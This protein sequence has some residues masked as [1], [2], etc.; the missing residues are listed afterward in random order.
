MSLG[1]KLTAVATCV[2]WGSLRTA[3]QATLRA[4]ARQ[5]V[6][7]CEKTNI[8]DIYDNKE[9]LRNPDLTPL[10]NILLP[11]VSYDPRLHRFSWAEA[12]SDFGLELLQLAQSRH[13]LTVEWAQTGE[14]L[15]QSLVLWLEQPKQRAILETAAQGGA[16]RVS[17]L[18][19]EWCSLICDKW[20]VLEHKKQI[21][22][23]NDLRLE[24]DDQ[25]LT[26]SWRVL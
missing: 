16:N 8:P 13:K 22:L 18:R 20:A 19:H 3:L 26:I 5:G 11:G 7:N 9:L 24:I 2:K 12:T 17:L 23:P 10:T 14:Q 6:L 21:S 1:E 15:V 25:R 4:R